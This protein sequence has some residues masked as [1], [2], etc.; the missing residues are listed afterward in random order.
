[1]NKQPTILIIEDDIFLNNIYNKRLSGE[2]F[3]V[4]TAFDGE[5]GIKAAKQKLPD[6]I[7]LDLMLPKMDGFAI[8]K[9]CKKDEDLKN[10]PIILLTNLNDKDDIEKALSLGVK[11]YLIKVHF[12]PAEVVDKIKNVL[13]KK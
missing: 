3:N 11:D 2:N 8:I 7:L 12:T 10:I 13:S 6:L 9:Y 5:K 4:L 1:M